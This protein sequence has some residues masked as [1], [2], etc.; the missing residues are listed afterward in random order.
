[1]VVGK[2]RV[3][4]CQVSQ[5]DLSVKLRKKSRNHIN[6]ARGGSSIRPMQSYLLL[7]FLEFLFQQV[8]LRVTS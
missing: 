1:M 3:A 8:Q 4:R 7:K 6:E 5:R 2:F